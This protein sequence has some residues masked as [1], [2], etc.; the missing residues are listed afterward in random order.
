MSERNPEV[1]LYADEAIVDNF[2]GGGGAS[3]GIEMALGRS[4]DVAINHD[5]D[6]LAMHRANHPTTD[7]IPDDVFHVNPVKV[8]KG[9]RC[10]LAWFSPDCTYF[11]KAKGLAPFRDPNMARR[12]RGLIG[13]VLKWAANPATRPRI[14]CIENVEEIEFWCPLG[15]D[16]RPDPAKR[17][18]SFKRWCARLRGFGYTVEYRKLRGSDFGAPTSRT[19]LYIVARCDGQPVAWPM[20][21]HGPQTTRKHRPVAECIDFDLPVPSIF[22]T[23]DEA[24]AWGKAHGVPAPR[25]PLALPTLRRIGRGVWRYVID[26][27]EPFIINVRHQGGD[28]GYSVHDPL[29]TIPASD[30]EF[31]LVAPTLINTRNGE[32]VGQQ[33]RIYDIRQP[34]GTITAAGSQGALV[35]AFLA[36]HNGGHEATGQRLL[37]P[38][39]TIT[40]V[41][42]KALVTS[43][44]I[45]LYGS[46]RDGAPVTDPS[47]TIT[48]H[49]NHIGEVRA[50]L[51]KFYNTGVAR[52]LRLPL[53]AITTQDRFGLVLVTIDGEDYIIVDIGM[54]MLTPRELFRAQG[55]PVDY[56]IAEGIHPE[57]GTPV[58]FTKRTQTR[59]VGNS[60]VPHVAAAIVR[61]NAT[62]RDLRQNLSSFQGGV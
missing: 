44:L 28:R 43:H 33:P 17:G 16:G 49:G 54:R 4:P 21:T 39:D 47:P 24:K 61:A 19:R 46:C 2:A 23:G 12:I 37:A 59:L 36:K 57:F 3:T 31:A 53:D 56:R 29:G 32:R 35:A 26:S 38:A 30:R 5:E 52:S 40:C 13:V 51:V 20:P 58:K 18:A 60:V 7:H 45:K 15:D 1:R 62:R 42:Q 27:P 10:G 25:R 55:F 22:M 8:L 48:A 9:R 14:I 6:A 41:D 50:F 11:S 34:Y